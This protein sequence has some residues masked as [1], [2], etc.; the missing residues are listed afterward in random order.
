LRRPDAVHADEVRE[1]VLRAIAS[2]RIP[3]GGPSEL[4]A[5]DLLGEAPPG[6]VERWAHKAAERIDEENLWARCTCAQVF[7]NGVSN[8]RCL[9][10]FGVAS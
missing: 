2:G 6:Y 8:D 5:H 9:R 3:R 4:A 7:E 10:C 1:H